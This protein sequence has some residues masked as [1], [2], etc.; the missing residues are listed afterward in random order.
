MSNIFTK[1]AILCY[2]ENVLGVG[3]NVGVWIGT[4]KGETMALKNNVASGSYVSWW[5]DESNQ[6]LY[7]IVIKIHDADTH[8]RLWLVE[9]C[10]MKAHLLYEHL[11]EPMA[12]EDYERRTKGISKY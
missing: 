4:G 1:N 2:R 10:T 3:V 7:G 6:I 12:Y 9:D 11:L 8:S 5:D